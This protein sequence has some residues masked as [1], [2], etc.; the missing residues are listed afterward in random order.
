MWRSLFLAIGI[1]FCIVG[2]E[3]MVIEEAV[4]ARSPAASIATCDGGG[5][6]QF[7]TQEWMPWSF[8]STGAVIILYT[9]TLPKRFQA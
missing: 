7:K 2:V 1:T 8:L 5:R 4:I 9:I 6:K 3:C